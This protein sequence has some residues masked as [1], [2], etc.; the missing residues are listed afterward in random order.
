MGIELFLFF[1]RFNFCLIFS[2]S[3][4]NLL[5][6]R[7]N[8]CRPLPRWLHTSCLA[9]L[10]VRFRFSWQQ[11]LL[12]CTDVVHFMTFLESSITQITHTSIL[13]VLQCSFTG[14]VTWVLQNITSSNLFPSLLSKVV[15]W[16]RLGIFTLSWMCMRQELQKFCLQL[17]QQNSGAAV[18]HASHL[19]C[20]FLRV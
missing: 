1:F 8:V 15:H 14:S 4:L 2:W 9:A 6:L 19:G 10:F 3:C 11:L 20:S 12:C 13:Q 17:K 5:K 18:V 7:R 16:W